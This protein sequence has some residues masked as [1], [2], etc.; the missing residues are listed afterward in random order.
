[1][2]DSEREAAYL[3]EYE[4]YATGRSHKI[5]VSFA[6]SRGGD[7][8]ER[9]LTNERNG[10]QLCHGAPLAEWASRLFAVAL[11]AIAFAQH[12]EDLDAKLLEWIKSDPKS[13]L[14]HEQYVH[15][16]SIPGFWTIYLSLAGLAYIGVVEG[17]AWV[18][19]KL[20]KWVTQPS[21]LGHWPQN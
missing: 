9:D 14:L 11:L 18:F 16:H 4:R 1:M 19:R 8:W 10:M 13:F 7:L 6:G 3:E 17:L 20:A 15:S 12:A 2:P 21:N 5:G